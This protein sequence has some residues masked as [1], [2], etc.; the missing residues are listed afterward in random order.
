MTAMILKAPFR[1]PPGFLAAFGYA[2]SRR[3]VALFWEPCG[4]EACFN[5]SVSYACGCSDNW[6]YLRFV[7]QPEV[8]QWL[9]A[10]SINLGNSDEPADHWLIADAEK[11][12]LF[13][14]PEREARAIVRQQQRPQAG[15]R[16]GNWGR[17]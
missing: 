16:A 9:D 10:N 3:L 11:G 15:K 17:W 14:V 8:R 2:G 5:D 7:R 1:L 6:L 12:D 13:A 4:D